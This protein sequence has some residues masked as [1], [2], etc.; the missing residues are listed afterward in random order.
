MLYSLM[1]ETLL[2]M[3]DMVWYIHNLS[4]KAIISFLE[5]IALYKNFINLDFRL[6]FTKG[7]IHQQYD[8]KAWHGLS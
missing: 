2:P 7:Y 6:R 5:L 1:L 4:K 8:L 3:I